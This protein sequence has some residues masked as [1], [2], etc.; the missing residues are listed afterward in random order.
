MT[1]PLP[2]EYPHWIKFYV[3]GGILMAA[4]HSRKTRGVYWSMRCEEG[5]AVKPV[6]IRKQTEKFKTN[7]DAEWLAVL[8]ALQYATE[9][10]I[11]M[12][13]VIYSDSLLVVNQFNGKWR[14]KIARHHRMRTLCHELA[15]GLKFVAVQW[16][17]R[18]VNVDKLGH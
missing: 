18:T 13:I 6:I 11:T 7:N 15:K 12:P 10:Q 14:A 2:P 3:D 4:R 9:K 17:P 1:A 8:E 5:S 16:V